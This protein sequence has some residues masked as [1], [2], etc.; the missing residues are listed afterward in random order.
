[1]ITINDMDAAGQGFKDPTPASP[2]GGNPGTT[3]GAQRMNAFRFAAERWA[4]ALD[5]TI[6][7]VIDATFS[8]LPCSGGEVV[9]G[10]ASAA[11]AFP[12]LTTVPPTL[13]PIALANHLEGM[14]LAPGEPDII[15]TFNGGLA[16]CSGGEV[17]WYYGYDGRGGDDTDLVEIVLHELAHGLGFTSFVDEETGTPFLVLDSFSRHVFDVSTGKSWAAMTDAERAASARNVRRLAWDGQNV[18]RQ[19][20][21]MMAKGSPR[22]A[23]VPPLAALSGHVSEAEFGRFVAAGA[24]SG[25]LLFGVPGP[26][27][28]E[29]S[30]SLSGKV[31]L[32]PA[33]SCA[34][35]YTSYA[36][37][38]AGA[39]AILFAEGGSPP[40]T[41]GTRPSYIPMYPVTIPV[42][43]ISAADGNALMGAGSPTVNLTAD[44]ARVVGGDES[45]RMYLF[46]SNPIQ[47]G[48]TVS[49]W[50]PLSR[51]D[52]LQ[53]PLAGPAA[54]HDLRME[55]ALFRDIGWRT[56]CGNGTVNSGE[57]CDE[58][59]DNGAP[60]AT[61]R[62]DC[63]R[64]AAGTGGGSGAGGAGGRGG[65]GGGGGGGR[66][67][68][69]S[70]SGTGG[71]GSGTG[72]S[73]AGSGGSGAGAMGGTGG[74]GGGSGGRGAVD[75][76]VDQG[77][78]GGGDETGCGCALPP[79][80]PRGGVTMSLALL[81]A[82]AAARRAR[83][84]P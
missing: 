34:S 11:E 77:T 22:I 72:G 75:A 51:P 79:A 68:G 18:T 65:S 56:V 50:D 2:V 25:P 70:G 38:M 64:V 35:I 9:L 23:T 69:G 78:P 12:L 54:P 49:H 74:D 80:T 61:C 36:A 33:T 30:G 71:S 16:A 47:P 82:L 63:T 24:A 45:G 41:V 48:S 27:T 31:V 84:R 76:G 52:L 43:G 37:Q 55:L 29:V 4:A 44:A 59:A 15:A 39:V 57:A 53:E 42:I 6:P 28:C 20:A 13:A 46:A 19:A 40:F 32:I 83:K 7:I 1:M 8:Q 62:P 66:G 5:S 73:G 26:P 58:G 3:V 81:G 14:D 10:Q 21:A 17:D 60:T 67:S